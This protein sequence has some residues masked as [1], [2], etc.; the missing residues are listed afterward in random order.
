MLTISLKFGVHTRNWPRIDFQPLEFNFEFYYW[1]FREAGFC[2]LPAKSKN[3]R[4]LYQAQ[5]LF[6]ITKKSFK[7]II[8]TKI[9]FISPKKPTENAF[10]AK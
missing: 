1:R 3:S 9:R 7:I 6:K 2:C 10:S 8:L 5:N 4:S